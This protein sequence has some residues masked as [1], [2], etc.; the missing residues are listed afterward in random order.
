MEAKR[1]DETIENMRIDAN[2]AVLTGFDPNAKHG[3]LRYG[4]S[5][6]IIPNGLNALVAGTRYGR[7][8]VEVLEEDVAVPPNLR[9]C[10]W[11]LLPP[12]QFVEKTKAGATCPGLRSQASLMTFRH[13]P[14]VFVQRTGSNAG[15]RSK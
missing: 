12:R 4:D 3:R 6:S 1:K 10:Q 14:Q 13:L 2:S 8:W 7:A 15:R 9:D 11:R 5:I